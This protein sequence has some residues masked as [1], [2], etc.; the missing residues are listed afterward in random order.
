[1]NL[2]IPGLRGENVWTSDD[3][4]NAPFVP[5]SLL[6]LGAGAVGVEFGYVFKRAGSKVNRRGDDAPDSARL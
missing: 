5:E 1:M 4:V 6:I 3:A 2:N